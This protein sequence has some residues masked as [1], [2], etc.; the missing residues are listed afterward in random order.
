MR[1]AFYHSKV[2]LHRSI[3]TSADEIG[4]LSPPLLLGAS[5]NDCASSAEGEA[6]AERHTRPGIGEWS[7][8]KCILSVASVAIVARLPVSVF[9]PQF[10]RRPYETVIFMFFHFFSFAPLPYNKR[11]HLFCTDKRPIHFLIE[12]AVVYR[13][14]G[15]A[16][17]F[18]VDSPV[19]G[20]RKKRRQFAG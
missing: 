8:L 7:R 2:N 13:I 1:K 14:P 10:K 18:T 20:R 12:A 15:T 11:Q 16:P 17:P 4:P 5:G 3:Q 19:D 9:R 6:Q